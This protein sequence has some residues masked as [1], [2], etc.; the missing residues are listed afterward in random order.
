LNI[1]SELECPE[2]IKGSGPTDVSVTIGS[3]PGS[4]PDAEIRNDFYEMTQNQFLMFV[5][6]VASYHVSNG[7]QIVIEPFSDADPREVRLFL[8]GSAFGVLLQQRGLVPMHASVVEMSG[9]AV[10][11]CGRSTIGKSTLAAI[12]YNRGY[13]MLTDDV[14]VVSLDKTGLPVVFPGYPQFKLSKDAL[15]VLKTHDPDKLTVVGPG[16][17]KYNLNTRARFCRNVLPLKTI[18][19]IQSSNNPSFG[20][21][22]IQGLDRFIALYYNTYRIQFL[23]NIINKS[24][25]YRICTAI[26]KYVDMVALSRPAATFL[27]EKLADLVEKDMSLKTKP[28]DSRLH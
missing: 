5:D 22:P 3:T 20:L 7:N 2:L 11:F 4:L 21:K 15:N 17:E 25:H 23:E 10:M 13:R 14:C 24:F 18:Y 12:L 28:A 27:P 16:L 8:L 1:F 9:Q 26:S 6:K 19:F